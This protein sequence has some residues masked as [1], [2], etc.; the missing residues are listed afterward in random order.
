VAVI[1]MVLT[2]VTD[3]W[4]SPAAK[5]SELY[6]S[7]QFIGGLAST[8]FLF[9]AGVATAM[10]A[11]AK[12]RREGN[13]KSGAALARRRGWEIFALGLLFRVQ[14]QVLGFAPLMNVFK[15]DMLNTMG[16]AI[17]AASYLW[18][19]SPD[20]RV[21]LG[22]LAFATTSITLLTPLVRSVG[23]LSPLPDPLEAYLR[24][25]GPYAAFP[26]FPWAGF[27]FAG[28]LVGD[29]VDAT[30]T[31]PRRAIALQSAL[32][33][34]AGAVAWL[35]W[36][37]SFRPALFPTASFWHDSPTF[38]FIRL[39]IVALAIPVAW[40][41]ERL[42]PRRWLQPL[43]TMGRSSLFV[44]WIHVEMVYGVIVEP[45]K[46][47]LPIWA[48]LAATAA[49]SLFLYG[50]VLLKNRWLERYDLRGPFRILAPVIR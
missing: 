49:M 5:Q 32:A 4:T 2:H 20:R 11:A 18:Q 46:G 44:Y 40:V 21:R 10:S 33:L 1:A 47:T 45:L 48:S 43:V 7:L 12:A 34:L 3:S 29:L 25:A 6:F 36:T 17:V 23:W 16:L 39:S 41:V 38:F 8:S 35:A 19:L 30:K 13:L 37:A 24:P 22:I 42:L 28:A 26:L 15:V 50:L 31:A 27:V 9:L 14:A